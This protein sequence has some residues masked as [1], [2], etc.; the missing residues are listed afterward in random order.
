MG[1]R[2]VHDCSSMKT[3]KYINAASCWCLSRMLHTTALCLSQS[4]K[5][6]LETMIFNWNASPALWH[7]PFLALC[8]DGFLTECHRTVKPILTCYDFISK[9]PFKLF[10]RFLVSSV[11]G[12]NYIQD[13]L[14]LQKYTVHSQKYTVHSIACVAYCRF[15]FN[16]LFRKCNKIIQ[17]EVGHPEGLRFHFVGNEAE[18]GALPAAL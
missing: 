5:G 2:I 16:G 12:N 14:V 6:S 13:F 1:L 17:T 15:N 3:S 8:S 10:L 11:Y 9:M 7:N 18:F 4:L